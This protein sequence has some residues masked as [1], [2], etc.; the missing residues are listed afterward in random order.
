MAFRAGAEILTSI[1]E[2]IS[3][4]FRIGSLFAEEACLTLVGFWISGFILIGI[5]HSII[6]A[7]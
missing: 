3:W 7:I 4:I 2:G 1:T 6:G 5:G